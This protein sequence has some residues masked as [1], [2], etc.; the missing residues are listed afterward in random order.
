MFNRF[1]NKEKHT[2]LG[3][4]GHNESQLSGSSFSTLALGFDL[5]EG[6]LDVT[7]YCQY[8]FTI[9]FPFG[10]FWGLISEP[11]STLEP[12]PQPFLFEFVFYIGPCTFARTALGL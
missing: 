3:I 12:Y 4:L 10:K 9:F 7:W 5:R 11:C 1:L 8:L 6:S 2:L